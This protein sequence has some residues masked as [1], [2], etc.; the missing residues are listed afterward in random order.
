[1]LCTGVTTIWPRPDQSFLLS[2]TTDN[3]LNMPVHHLND[4]E[5]PHQQLAREQEHARSMEGDNNNVACQWTCHFVWWWQHHVQPQVSTH[6]PLPKSP[7]WPWNRCHVIDVATRWW[8]LSSSFQTTNDWPQ[9]QPTTIMTTTN[10]NHATTTTAGQH[11]VMRQ[12][13]Q[14]V[15]MT[16]P[17][18]HTTHERHQLQWAP[19]MTTH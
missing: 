18:Q 1:M 17:Q 11:H 15:T 16:Q 8:C 14:D 12:W 7:C 6:S 5:T 10:D 3:H 2:L 9:W 19:N 4:T 13:H